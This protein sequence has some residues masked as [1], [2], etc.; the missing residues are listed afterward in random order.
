MSDDSVVF[1]DFP[2]G[3]IP[4]QMSRRALF[5][6]IKNRVHVMRSQGR[7]AQAY[8]LAQLGEWS[9]EDLAEVQPMIVPN[10]KISTQDNYVCAQLPEGVALQKLF[11]IDSPA[12]IVFNLFNGWNPLGKIS[13]QLAESNEWDV[14]YSF[15]YARGVFLSLVKAGICRPRY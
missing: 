9:D 1:E 7:G 4:F 5:S 8:T 6:E 12:L 14:Q 10:C 13:Q 15:D 3:E 11:Q 2:R